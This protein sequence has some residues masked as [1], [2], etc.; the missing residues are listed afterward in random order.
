[1]MMTIIV[2]STMM[3]III[4]VKD[5]LRMRCMD[6]LPTPAATADTTVELFLRRCAPAFYFTRVILTFI[7][8]GYKL[9]PRVKVVYAPHSPRCGVLWTRV[10]KERA[11]QRL[12]GKQGHNHDKH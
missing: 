12:S 7:L 1:M 8:P 9:R 5:F 4:N 3:S 6:N 2:I 11:T 10:A